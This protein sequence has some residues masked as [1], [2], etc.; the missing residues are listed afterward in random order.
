MDDQLRVTGIV[1]AGGMSRRL[2]RQKALEPLAGEPMIT[3]VIGRLSP[4]VKDEVVVVVNDEARVAELPLPESVQTAVDR[5]PGV[6]PLG[7]ILTGLEASDTD[8]S[9]AVSCD[10]PFLSARLFDYMLDQRDSYDAVI[11]LIKGRPEPTHGVY[12]K[13]CLPHMERKILAG[14]LK[15]ASFFDDVRVNFVHED[16]LEDF[17]PGLI[18][19][20]NVNTQSDMDRTLALV[21]RGF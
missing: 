1:L 2:G 17:D 3:R 4:V 12:A 11:P 9:I 16:V 7:G 14:E 8:W 15:I 20:F 19:F 13:S 18:S 21:A 5:H 10:M 6:G